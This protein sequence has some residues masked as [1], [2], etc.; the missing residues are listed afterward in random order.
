MENL[1]ELLRKEREKN[2]ELMDAANAVL[3]A[4]GSG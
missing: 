4:Q 1:K 2:Q 3:L